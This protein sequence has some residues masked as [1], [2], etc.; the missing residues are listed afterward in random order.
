MEPSRW[1]RQDRNNTG[2]H[3]SLSDELCP[4]RGA[5][6]LPKQA[7]AI[8][9]VVKYA[10]L[11]GS[12]NKRRRLASSSPYP[13]ISTQKEERGSITASVSVKLVARSVSARRTISCLCRLPAAGA[14]C[15]R[16]GGSSDRSGGSTRTR[17]NEQA[18]AASGQR[19]P[20]RQGRRHVAAGPTPFPNSSRRATGAGTP[21]EGPL[22]SLGLAH[23]LESLDDDNLFQG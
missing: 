19:N 23:S 2:T 4:S 11:S 7:D 20:L 1:N 15:L 22:R 14:V 5:L 10:G 3:H 9:P 8:N 12:K 18:C 21:A 13:T 6:S 17:F 16:A